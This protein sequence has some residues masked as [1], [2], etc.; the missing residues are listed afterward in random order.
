MH[1]DALE[2][3]LRVEDGDDAAV[4]SALSII[5]EEISVVNEA[6][7]CEPADQAAWMFQRWL[8]RC[9]G[10]LAQSFP[11]MAKSSVVELITETQAN[12]GELLSMEPDCKWVIMAL[13]FLNDL[14]AEFGDS[15]AAGD[16]DAL[17]RAEYLDKLEEIDPMHAGYYAHLRRSEKAE[18]GERS[19]KSKAPN[20]AFIIA[21]HETHGFFLLRAFKKRK[22]GEHFQ[23]PGG[24]VDS[25]D[26][27]LSA[28]AAR[29][30]FEET[31]IDIRA[32]LHRLDHACVIKRRAY[33]TLALTDADAADGGSAHDADS[34]FSVL[35]SDEHTGFTFET[36]FLKASSMVAMHSGGHGSTA[37][38]QIYGTGE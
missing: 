29:E 21:K 20:R 10:D 1:F 22:G 12:C 23:L 2:G 14:F 33:F 34:G 27:S 16:A 5:A 25:T 28:A 31:G 17:Q 26:E 35:L 11:S 24:H 36:D 9:A 19:Q 32:T 30:L 3:K 38:K 4:S 18:K 7:F 8:F 6:T 13:L 15:G 37:L